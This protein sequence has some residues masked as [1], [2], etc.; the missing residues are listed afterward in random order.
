MSSSEMAPFLEDDQ[1]IAIS[2]GR[3]VPRLDQKKR[4]EE[5]QRE[6]TIGLHNIQL[7]SKEKQAINQAPTETRDQVSW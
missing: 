6:A 7:I 4:N 5:E 1:A 3:K 2:V